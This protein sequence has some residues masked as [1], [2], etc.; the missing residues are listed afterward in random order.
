MRVVPSALREPQYFVS[1][2]KTN[3]SQDEEEQKE[4]PLKLTVLVCPYEYGVT[5]PSISGSE[6]CYPNM[7]LGILVQVDKLSISN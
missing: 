5:E 4:N 1:L 3:P 2:S 7:I 6:C